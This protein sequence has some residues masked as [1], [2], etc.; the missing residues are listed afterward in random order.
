MIKRFRFSQGMASIPLMIVLLLMA[1]AVP[2]ATMLVQ[3]NA[4]TRNM[5]MDKNAKTY[6]ECRKTGGAQKCAAK[7]PTSKPKIPNGSGGSGTTNQPTLRPGWH[8][9]PNGTCFDDRGNE[10]TCPENFPTGPMTTTCYDGGKVVDCSTIAKPTVVLKPTDTCKCSSNGR[11]EGSNCS[12]I[13]EGQV[14]SDCYCGASGRR[15]GNACGPELGTICS[16]APT[17][18]LTPIPTADPKRCVGKTSGQACSGGRVYKCNQYG[19]NLPVYAICQSGQCASNGTDCLPLGVTSMVAGQ[20]TGAFLTVA[21]TTSP[22]QQYDNCMKDYGATV[23]GCKKYLVSTVAPTTSPQQQYDNCMKDYGA[24]SERCGAAYLTATVAPTSKPVSSGGNTSSGVVANVV[25]TV[26]KSSGGNTGTN[27]GTSTGTDTGSCKESCVN[28]STLLQNC[29]PPESDGSSSDSSCNVEGR[30]E[31][32]GGSCFTCAATG[33]NWKKET[34]LSKCPVS[35]QDSVLNYE[36]AF[37]GVNPSS[38]QCVIGWPLQFIVL[39]GGESQSYTGVI[40]ESM[41]TVGNKLVFSGSLTLTGFSQTSGVAAFVKGPKHL[42]M[43]YGKNNQTEAYSQAGGEITLTADADT[44]PVYNF[45]GY[46][47]LPGDVVDASLDTQDGVINGV[48]YAFIRAKSFVHETIASGGYLKGDLDGNCQ[49][50]SNDV[51][52]YKI[53]LQDKQGQLY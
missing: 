43:K 25:P 40:P 30:A 28:G 51:N 12:S 2:V 37:G 18:V 9:D 29:T 26:K 7:F 50:N 33:G 10:S 36:I 22:Q 11:L 4:D 19:D 21:P 46:P 8:R 52:I 44:S 27:T 6:D 3:Q 48:D 42:Q 17:T 24:T 14:C 5:A 20:P 34:D 13:R 47:L 49:V 35:G 41:A 16:V 15:E 39:G 38:S 31:M 45:S 23:A 53:S 1:I 32:C